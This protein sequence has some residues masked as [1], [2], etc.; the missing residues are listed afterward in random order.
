[1]TLRRRGIPFVVSAPS[2]TGKTT[3]C[4]AV[5]SRDARIRFSVSHTTRA[6][7]PGEV[8]GEHYSFVTRSEFLGL[9]ADGGFA[10]HAEYAG[11]LYGTSFAALDK[12][13]AAGFDLL[14]EIEVQGAMELRARRGDARFVF[15]LP[16]T[17]A[18]LE[19][20]LRARATDGEAVIAARLEAVRS[21]LAALHRFD[22]AV[23]NEN[24]EQ[25]TAALLAI[26]R[27]ERSGEPR[28]LA[29]IRQR[30]DRAR[31]TE[32]LGAVLP[33]PEGARGAG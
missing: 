22:Y 21:E 26:V 19:R 1:M 12:P 33:I 25:S 31:V 28:A 8:N 17:M 6:P 27:A 20:R 18:E 23:V 32:S 30:F 24:A 13:L 9:V 2:G 15:L 11:H 14:L 7:R 3:I 10:E 4:R 29:A 16:P 5:V